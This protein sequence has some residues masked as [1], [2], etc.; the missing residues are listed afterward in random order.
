MGKRI[1]FFTFAAVLIGSLLWAVQNRI[2]VATAD[3]STDVNVRVSKLE[4]QIAELEKKVK[5]LEVK[6]NSKTIAIPFTKNRTA[7][8]V[9]PG[10][11]ERKING[12]KYWIMPLNENSQPKPAKPTN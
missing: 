4:K 3:S 10:S 8:K 2:V 6:A 9:P 12:L 1:S 5:E 11:I 7:D